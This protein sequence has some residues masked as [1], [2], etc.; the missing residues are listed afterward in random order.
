MNCGKFAM[1][2]VC[3]CAIDPELSIT[4]STSIFWHPVSLVPSPGSALLP[5]PELDEA[6]TPVPVPGDLRVGPQPSVAATS[7][8]L[9]QEV[10]S[11][12][13]IMEDLPRVGARWVGRGCSATPK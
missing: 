7:E 6:S 13:M 9:R 3:S 4:N 12:R 1:R 10:P 8:M 2:L 11:E 5:S